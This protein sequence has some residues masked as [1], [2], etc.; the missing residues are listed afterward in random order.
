MRSAK[1]KR[2]GGRTYRN[3]LRKLMPAI[4]AASGALGMVDMAKA[5]NG[6]WTFLGNG[7]SG[8]SSNW[9]SETIADGASSIADFSKLNI[10]ADTTVSLDAPHTVGQLLIGDAT[11]ASNSWTFDIASNAA[12][13]LTLDNG[14]A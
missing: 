13:H 7:S 8:L 2:M 11:T 9:L 6:T 12:N 5:T 1:S 4:V 3:Q 10:T 14:A